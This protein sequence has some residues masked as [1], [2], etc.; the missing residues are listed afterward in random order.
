MGLRELARLVL[1]QRR[2]N[3]F[4]RSE[5]INSFVLVLGILGGGATWFRGCFCLK[6]KEWGEIINNSNWW[7]VIF[8]KSVFFFVVLLIVIYSSSQVFVSPLPYP[9][10]LKVENAR[11]RFAFFIVCNS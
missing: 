11:V 1:F 10:S 6:T 8:N 2:R 9:P 4:L 5:L 3:R 7:V